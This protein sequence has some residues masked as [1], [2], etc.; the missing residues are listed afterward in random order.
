MGRG[1]E[2]REKKEERR[3]K[4]E[5][6]REKKEERRRKREEGREKKEERRRKREE[7]KGRG[8]WKREN[9]G[10]KINKEVDKKRT[11]Y[12]LINSTNQR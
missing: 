12:K 5:E 9:G 8:K 7:E 1:R 2:G 3:R 4:R 10:L 11:L 6:G